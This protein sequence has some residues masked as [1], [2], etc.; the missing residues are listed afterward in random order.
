VI[1][2]PLIQRLDDQRMI[3]YQDRIPDFY[4][5]SDE[6]DQK[7]LVSF[8]VISTDTRKLEIMA[9]IWSHYVNFDKFAAFLTHNQVILVSYTGWTLYNLEDGTQIWQMDAAALEENMPGLLW[10]NLDMLTTCV[11]TSTYAIPKEQHNGHFYIIDFLCPEHSQQFKLPLM[12]KHAKLDLICNTAN[13][14]VVQMEDNY[15]ILDLSA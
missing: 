12:H 11:H 2:Y 1:A 6:D 15:G 13:A 4:S 7:Y 9:P 10:F 3:V 5:T 8:A 14:I